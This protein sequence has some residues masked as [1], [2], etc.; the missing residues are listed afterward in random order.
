[1]IISV[2]PVLLGNGTRLFQEGRP[3]Q[4][5]ELVNTKTFET[6]LIQMHYKRKTAA[7]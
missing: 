6:G 7:N 5:L 4:Q 1:M 2:I 3:E